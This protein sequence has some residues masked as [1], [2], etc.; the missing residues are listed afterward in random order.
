MN[1]DTN[2]GEVGIRS[3]ILPLYAP[4]LCVMFGYGMIIPVLPLFARF[5]G[6]GLGLTG[7]IVS[8]RGVGSL[9]F[10]LPAGAIISRAGRLPVLLLSA[11]ATALTAA[12]TGSIERLLPLAILTI[13][14]GAAH[15]VWVLSIQTHI[16]QNFPAY[17]RGRAM[18]LVGGTTR[19]GW[20]LGPIVGGYLGRRFGLQAVYFGQALVCSIAVILLLIGSSHY[21]SGLRT[22]RGVPFRTAGFPFVRTVQGRWRS[23]LLLGMVVITLQ[24][25]RMGRQTILP[26]WGERVALDVAAIGLIFGISRAVELLLFYPAGVLMDRLGRKWTAV[27]CIIL[28]SLSLAMI[29]LTRG[30]PGLLLVSMIAGIGNGL[31]AGIVLTLGADL[32]P[33]TATGE[34][35]GIWHLMG[36]IGAVS[37]PLLIGAVAQSLGLLAAPLIIAGIGIAGAWL[38]IYRVTETLATK[39][40]ES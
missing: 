31:G 17:R 20:V 34:F 39:G 30:F 2:P 26:L 11:A 40:P 19:I 28:Q 9:L 35:L 27:P 24:I 1:A 5:L 14:M 7:V 32:S 21:R 4:T 25:L 16:R 37:G 36:D 33:R 29:P 8:L 38:M 6:A 3:L 13:A 10:D 22:Q 23:F 12:V 18:A 15:V